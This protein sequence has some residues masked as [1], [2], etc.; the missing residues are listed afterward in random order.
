MGRQAFIYL[1]CH[2]VHK[3]MAMKAWR[4]FENKMFSNHKTLAAKGKKKL[5]A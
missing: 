1:L 2:L 3:N 5:D 4:D